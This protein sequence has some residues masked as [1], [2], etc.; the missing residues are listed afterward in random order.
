MAGGRPTTYTVELTDI[1]CERLA[2]GE[3]MRSISLNEDMPAMSTLFK[4][5]RE[6]DEFSEQYTRAKQESADT[7]TDEMLEIADSD[8]A[9]VD[10]VSVGHARLRIETRKWLA[11]KLK[12]KKYGDKITQ[13]HTGKDGGAIKYENSTDEQLDAK[14]KA[15]LND[16]DPTTE[17]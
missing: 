12:P 17:D 13:E 15:L 4:W 10:A 14:I 7:L 1:I 8:E 6:H 16:T 3:S 5:L 2:L 11:S 9:K